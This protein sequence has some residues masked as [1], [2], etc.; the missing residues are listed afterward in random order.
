MYWLL[1][2]FL[3]P[4]D[5]EII[6]QADN[7]RQ[8]NNCSLSI[9]SRLGQHRV[10][11]GETIEAIASKYNLVRETLIRLNPILQ[12]GLPPIGT[13]IL[14]PPINGIRVEVPRGATW[15]DLEGAYGVRRDVLFELNGCQENPTV[16]FIPGTNW[17][18]TNKKTLN[19]LGL[20]VYPLSNRAKIGLEYGWNNTAN[21]Q[22]MFHSGIDLLATIGSPVLSA[23]T[24]IVVFAGK[25]GN[26]GNLIVINHGD[27]LQT[28]YAHLDSIKVTTGQQVS[29]G[30]TIGTVGTTG[31]PDIP[32]PHLHF[33][34]RYRSPQ[35]WLAQDPQLHLP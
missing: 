15:Q 8:P 9:L 1:N 11:R 34:V 16:V 25:Q 3:T 5:N 14:I 22:S 2:L 4:L 21:G 12:R 31:Q 27:K 26:Y 17:D 13:V 30:D 23:E 29:A 24:G 35:G 28:R 18:P 6:V 10:T 20:S 7:A 32:N 19:Y 33:E